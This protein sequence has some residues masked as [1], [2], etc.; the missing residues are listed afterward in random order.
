MMEELM[1][2][3]PLAEALLAVD[4]CWGEERCFL[5]MGVVTARLPML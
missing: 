2:P 3:Y 4:G 5:L 1:R